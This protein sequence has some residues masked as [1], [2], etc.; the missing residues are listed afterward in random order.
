[1]EL[2]QIV[3]SALD[4]IGGLDRLRAVQTY[5]AEL[6]RAATSGPAATTAITVWRAAGG[7]IRVE[8]ISPLGQNIRIVDGGAGM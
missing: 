5:R 8:E 3:A 2:H 4:A 1:M 6:L 7:R